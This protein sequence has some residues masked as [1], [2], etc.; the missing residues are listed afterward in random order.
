MNSECFLTSSLIL[1]SSAYSYAS[2]FKV[3]IILDPLFSV[4]PL[5]SLFISKECAA[6][7]SQTY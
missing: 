5:G 4:F 6:F 7:D 2:Y 1:S 3:I